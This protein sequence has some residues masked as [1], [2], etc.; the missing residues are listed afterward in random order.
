MMTADQLLEV[1]HKAPEA[2]TAERPWYIGLL[3]GVAGWFAGLLLLVFVGAVLTPNS[4]PSAMLTGAVLF[5]AAWGL[6]RID[7]DGAFVSQLAIALSIAG[8]VAMLFGIH[9]SVFKSS[10]TGIASIAM[11]ALLI[12][13]A[14]V[15]L[16]PSSLHRTMST[17]FACIAW[18]IF[19]RYGLW[20]QPFWADWGSKPKPPPPSLGMALLGWIVAW[21]PAGGAL[22]ILGWKE[23]A[24]MAAGRQSLARPL[25]TGLIFGLAFATLISH[26]FEAFRLFGP[27]EAP[28]L[29]WLALWPLLSALASLG[30]LAAAF[31]LGSRGLMGLCVLAALLHVS[32]FYYAMGTSLLLKS[33][34]MGVMGVAC[35]AAARYLRAKP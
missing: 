1:L 15:L 26:P 4:G 8:Q 19:V 3:L 29:G 10:N 35:I 20:D 16:M 2:A 30:A 28:K 9:E 7:R 23:A 12:Q 6:F 32:H 5:A 21:A 13:L 34:L 24:W 25:A 18:A 17:L 14:L 27:A 31:A 22:F 33:L 11:V